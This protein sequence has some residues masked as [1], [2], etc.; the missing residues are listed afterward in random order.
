MQ[1]RFVLALIVSCLAL[2]ASAAP[3]PAP[4]SIPRLQQETALEIRGCSLSRCIYISKTT[5]CTM[6]TL[7]NLGSPQR[8]KRPVRAQSAKVFTQ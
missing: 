2:T 8:P 5:R 1:S 6:R 4:E 7:R 3:V